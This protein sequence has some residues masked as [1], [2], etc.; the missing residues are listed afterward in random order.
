MLEVWGFFSY[1][2]FRINW[3][4]EEFKIPYVVHKI[5]SRTGETQ[6]KKYLKMNPK[7]KIPI[8]KHNNLIITESLA[9]INYIANNFKKGE[10]FYFPTDKAKKA[11]IDEWNVFCAMELDCLGI[12][13]LRKHG[14]KKNYGL[15]EIYGRAP[16][17]IRAAEEHFKKMIK[18]CDHKIPKNN[19]LLGTKVSCADIMFMSC[20]QAAKF[21]KI[22]IGSSRA[23]KYYER[24]K[25]KKEYT[26]A[27][28]KTYGEHNLIL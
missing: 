1:R 9:A 4:L 19:F 22:R 13:I 3:I 15:S 12:Y 27:L 21:F 26:N 5:G 18:A 8:L 17:A 6:T 10:N 24:V 2:V 7:G 14:R 20:L 23:C 11:K 28:K 25:Q 16:N